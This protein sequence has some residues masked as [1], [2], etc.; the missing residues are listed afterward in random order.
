MALGAA[1]MVIESVMVVWGVEWDNWIKVG[2][3]RG[4]RW[5]RGRTLVGWQHKLETS[6]G[7]ESLLVNLVVGFVTGGLAIVIVRGRRRES[8]YCRYGRERQG[9]HPLGRLLTLATCSNERSCSRTEAS[10]SK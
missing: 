5:D 6:H 3:H 7:R 10:K 9:F 4:E 2:R 1:A 8:Y